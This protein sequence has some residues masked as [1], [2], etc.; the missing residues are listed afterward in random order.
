ML[1]F[2]YSIFVIVNNRET[3]SDRRKNVQLYAKI[4]KSGESIGE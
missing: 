3:T 1:K 2:H 4:E